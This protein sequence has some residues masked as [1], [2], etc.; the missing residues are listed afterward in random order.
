MAE[1]NSPSTP[2]PP[3]IKREVNMGQLIGFII[4]LVTLFG[5]QWW[6]MSIST[7]KNEQ[8]IKSLEENYSDVA[9]SFTEALEKSDLKAEA[10]D[11]RITD[12]LEVLT[13]KVENKK[14]K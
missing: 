3:F 7:I 4:G 6:D 2:P 9:K 12:K 10:R 13:I 5:A 11:Q 14:D 1:T 8:R